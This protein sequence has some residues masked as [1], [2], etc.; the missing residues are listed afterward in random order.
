M[1][2][3]PIKD[4]NQR[5]ASLKQ[6]KSRPDVSNSVVGTSTG[7]ATHFYKG[8]MPSVLKKYNI[9]TLSNP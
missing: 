5:L 6:E 1:N 2:L 9:K 7:S 8:F 3:H 4:K